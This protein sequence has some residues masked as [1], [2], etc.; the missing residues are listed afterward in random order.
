MHIFTKSIAL[1][2]LI[3]SL[4]S[5]GKESQKQEDQT[6]SKSEQPKPQNTSI[7]EEIDHMLEGKEGSESAL[8]KHL[9]GKP[10]AHNMKLVR[11]GISRFEKAHGTRPDPE[12]ISLAIGTLNIITAKLKLEATEERNAKLLE[13]IER[14]LSEQLEK[15]RR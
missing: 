3:T 15:E 8:R 2:F 9:A 11:G 4:I 7:E 14:K 10:K 5:C 13:E 12:N 6:P 1:F